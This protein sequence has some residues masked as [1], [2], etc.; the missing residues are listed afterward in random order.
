MIGMNDAMSLRK[1]PEWGSRA[2]LGYGRVVQCTHADTES[3]S[4]ISGYNFHPIIHSFYQPGRHIDE[5]K[6][7]L[8]REAANQMGYRLVKKTEKK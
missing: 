1:E 3:L 5:Q 8:V 4:L 7:E 2:D 6:L